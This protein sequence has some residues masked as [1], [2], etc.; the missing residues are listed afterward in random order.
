MFLRVQRVYVD[1]VRP[2][3]NNLVNDK[4][5]WGVI[6]EGRV[7]RA[8]ARGATPRPVSESHMSSA[9]QKLLPRSGARWS[10]ATRVIASHLRS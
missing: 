5:C 4:S 9:A 6:I 7:V 8:A 2:L 3:K 10:A 1:E